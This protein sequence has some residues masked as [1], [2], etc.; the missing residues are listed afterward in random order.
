[1]KTVLI[2]IFLFLTLTAM[3]KPVIVRDTTI[4]EFSDTTMNKRVTII[5]SGNKEITLPVNLNLNNV[6][7]ALGIDTTERERAVVLV[8]KAVDKRD[9]LLL[10]SQDGHRIQIIGNTSADKFRQNPES[11]RIRGE[12][13]EGEDITDQYGLSDEN[14]KNQNLREKISD[15][16]KSDQKKSSFFPK[17]DFG[18]Y[19]GLN[20]LANDKAGP[21]ENSDLRTWRSRYV[22]LSFRKN[23]TIVRGIGADMALSYGPEVIWYN[24]MFQNSQ[25]IQI[26]NNTPVY[27]PAG[28]NTQKTKLVVPALNFPVMLSVGIKKEKFKVG[29]GGYAGY[30]FG[31]YTKTKNLEGNKEKIKGDYQLSEFLYGLTAELGRRNGF[32]VFLRYDLNTL[33]DDQSNRP[34]AL[35]FGLRF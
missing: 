5:T 26:V 28:F 20:T 4:I 32:T 10:I 29:V 33:F 18:L 25:T 19:V 6:L 3:S 23:S 13:D 12:I 34:N 27:T 11:R 2:P 14:E 22:A 8:D 31:G 9:T 7:K 17:S 1:M 15:R 16:P 35:S 21:F 30:R 24:Y